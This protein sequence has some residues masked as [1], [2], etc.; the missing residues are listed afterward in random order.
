MQELSFA[1]DFITSIVS[2][3]S[4]TGTSLTIAFEQAKSVRALSP[5]AK[6][7]IKMVKKQFTLMAR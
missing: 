7:T 4:G 3:A 2:L 1:V 6:I 5:L